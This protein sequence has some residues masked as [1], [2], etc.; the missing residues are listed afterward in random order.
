MG[1]A[2]CSDCGA[3]LLWNGVSWV[4]KTTYRR[5]LCRANEAPT[6]RYERKIELLEM[7]RDR[8]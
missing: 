7:Q 5:H 2:P 4:D 8:R 1:P 3:P 6:R